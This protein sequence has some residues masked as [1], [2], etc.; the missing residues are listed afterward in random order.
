MSYL[1]NEVHNVETLSKHH[2]VDTHEGVF[3]HPW[4]K[5]C[6]GAPDSSARRIRKES[7]GIHPSICGD[8]PGSAGTP[9]PA[10]SSSSSSAV[11]PSNTSGEV[12]SFEKLWQDTQS[13]AQEKIQ[14]WGHKVI[15]G[16]PPEYRAHQAHDVGI[17]PIVE[18]LTSRKDSSGRPIMEMFEKPVLINDGVNGHWKFK[19]KE[20][21]AR[22]ITSST[23]LSA[24]NMQSG[25]HGTSLLFLHS[26]LYHGYL[27]KSSS[28]IKRGK[29]GVYRS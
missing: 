14:Y 28:N 17:E 19:V 5:I 9:D 10:P 7:G 2:P 26:I 8:A 3:V 25:W 1:C 12:S 29:K 11:E 6:G 4:V 16:L 27:F 22:P 13:V 21:R 23:A 15:K 18:F 24:Q 20:N